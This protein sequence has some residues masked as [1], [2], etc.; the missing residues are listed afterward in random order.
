VFTLGR[1]ERNEP[2]G[3][4]FGQCLLSI[5]SLGQEVYTIR[6][7]YCDISLP[8]FEFGSRKCVCSCRY[9]NIPTC[10]ICRLSYQNIFGVVLDACGRLEP[11]RY[12]W[13]LIKYSHRSGGE[14]KHVEIFKNILESGKGAQASECWTWTRLVSP[15]PG[16]EKKNWNPQ[17]LGKF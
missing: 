12:G 6:L 9:R 5:P 11:S 13:I 7:I 1:I 15:A 8:P 16:R 17:T 4:V 3:S 14:T 10:R 2:R